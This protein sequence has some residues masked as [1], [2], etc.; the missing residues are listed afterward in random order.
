MV[1]VSD[2]GARRIAR[3]L[4]F[5]RVVAVGLGTGVT[6]CLIPA[7]EDQRTVGARVNS[8]GRSIN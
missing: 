4:V 8:H 2:A 6:D 1:R 5:S 7:T 3:L